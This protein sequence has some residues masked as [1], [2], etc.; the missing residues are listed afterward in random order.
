MGEIRDGTES[1]VRSGRV[2]RL[3]G[4]FDICVQLAEHSGGSACSPTI[5]PSASDSEPR[6]PALRAATIAASNHGRSRDDFT[7]L[8]P[9]R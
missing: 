3:A 8:R 1:N 7:R 6:R 2:R 4:G 5:D 9:D